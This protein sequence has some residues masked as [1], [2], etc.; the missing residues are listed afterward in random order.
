MPTKT[1]LGFCLR[2]VLVYIVLMIPWPGVAR[3]YG[4]LYRIGGDLVFGTFSFGA[5]V[6][7]QAA[8]ASDGNWDTKVIIKN[9]RSGATG[10]LPSSSRHMGYIP[11]AVFVSLV[12]ATPIVWKRKRQALFWGFLWVNIYVAFRVWLSIFDALSGQGPGALYAL[13][14]FWKQILDDVRHVVAI[15]P[16]NWFVAP[17]FIWIL[18]SFRSEDWT[19]FS[20]PGK[21]AKKKTPASSPTT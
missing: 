20:E 3:A 13:S 19:R 2:L 18:V 15:V 4:L 14:P 5:D 21:P 17:V 12:L 8:D 6:H 1:I 16:A 11:T 10:T 7:F 9:H